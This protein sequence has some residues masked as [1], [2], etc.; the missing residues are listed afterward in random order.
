MGSREP[1]SAWGEAGTE[2][3]GASDQ[4]W[5]PGEVLRAVDS[6]SAHPSSSRHSQQ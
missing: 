4:V 3:G 2:T 1:S 5:A 6:V